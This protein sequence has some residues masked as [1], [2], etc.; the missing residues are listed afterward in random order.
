MKTTSLPRLK[1]NQCDHEW[2]PR[3]TEPPLSCPK[4][5]SYKWAKPK[6]KK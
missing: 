2:S 4:C 3:N 1:C 5:K 6:V